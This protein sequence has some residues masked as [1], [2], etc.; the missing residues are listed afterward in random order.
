MTVL[1]RTRYGSQPAVLVR[2]NGVTKVPRNRDC[3]SWPPSGC[4]IKSLARQSS[5]TKSHA[6]T[7]TQRCNSGNSHYATAAATPT[8]RRFSSTWSSR[9]TRLADLADRKPMRTSCLADVVRP[10]FRVACPL[11]WDPRGGGSERSEACWIVVVQD[12]SSPDISSPDETCIVIA[13]Q[14]GAVQLRSTVTAW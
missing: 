5:C 8:C 14:S 3:E 1:R 11:L 7:R 12:R 10:A 6:L 13:S 9:L 2:L 4:S